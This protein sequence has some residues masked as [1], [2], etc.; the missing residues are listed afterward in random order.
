MAKE[1]VKDRIR[2]FVCIELDEPLKDEIWKLIKKLSALAPNLK[3]AREEA[4]HLTLKF[5]GNLPKATVE[6]MIQRLQESI[7]QSNIE[8]FIL[9]LSGI[10]GFP[11]LKRPRVLWLG[12]SGD[13][14][15][16]LGLQSIVEDVCSS[17]RE[18]HR[19]DKPFSPHLTLARIKRPSD[20]TPSIVEHLPLVEFPKLLWHVKVL[21]FMK[22]D[23]TPEGA[24][25]TPLARYHLGGAA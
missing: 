7:K 5:C 11:T 20:I 17:F 9:E 13:L 16:L 15:S 12:V 10:G 18:V 23:L 21:T 19:D 4:L 2:C 25:Y 6:I 22:S 3:W 24:I 14:T 8:P 1:E